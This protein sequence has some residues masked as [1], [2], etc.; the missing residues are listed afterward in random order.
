MSFSLSLSFHYLVCVCVCELF[1]KQ[2]VDKTCVLSAGSIC[3][4]FLLYIYFEEHRVHVCRYNVKQVLLNQIAVMDCMY[5]WI[6]GEVYIS[7]FDR[8]D[9][10]TTWQTLDNVLSQWCVASQASSL[11]TNLQEI[12][13]FRYDLVIWKSSLVN[14]FVMSTLIK[15]VRTYD[16]CNYCIYEN[17]HMQFKLMRII[18]GFI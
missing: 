2:F 1:L 15:T 8:L 18:F 16:C 13:V 4:I 6:H 11:Q 7:L 10:H 3:L 12:P 5:K 14:I 17:Q 9:F